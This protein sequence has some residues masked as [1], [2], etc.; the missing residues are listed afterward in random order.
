MTSKADLRNTF[1]TQVHALA[2]MASGNAHPALVVVGNDMLV[3][4]LHHPGVNSGRFPQK[5][6]G[7]CNNARPRRR[8]KGRR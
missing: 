8:V 1:F 3:D 7:D 4:R 2:S 6:G 5:S